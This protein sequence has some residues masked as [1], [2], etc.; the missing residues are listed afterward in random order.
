[1]AIL[2][3]F[4][5][6]VIEFMAEIDD[7]HNIRFKLIWTQYR[8]ISC[9]CCDDR[10]NDDVTCCY[11]C[12]DCFSHTGRFLVCGSED[13]FVYI[14][15]TQHEFHTFSSARRDRSDYWESI[16]GEC[17]NA[18]MFMCWLIQQSDVWYCVNACMTA[19]WFH[20]PID[21]HTSDIISALKRI[22][23]GLELHW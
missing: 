18:C 1:M 6:T 14:W 19:C 13:H 5:E 8:P 17:M 4:L 16:K 2:A 12:C 3:H 22:S 23:Y 15:R 9:C 11:C 7:Y 21:R 20:I 10:P